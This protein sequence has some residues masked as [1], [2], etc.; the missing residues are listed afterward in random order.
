MGYVDEDD[1]LPIVKCVGCGVEERAMY[2]ETPEQAGGLATESKGGSLL[3]CYG[4]FQHDMNLYKW[5]NKSLEKEGIYCDNCVT[6]L[7]NSGDIE[8]ERKNVW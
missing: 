1:E 4:S 3:G 7:L 8:I 6:N 2:F 5:K